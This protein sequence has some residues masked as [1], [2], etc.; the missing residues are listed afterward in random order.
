MKYPL[1]RRSKPSVAS[2]Q[3]TSAAYFNTVF[4]FS[5]LPFFYK[6]FHPPFY[7]PG[8]FLAECFD[9]TKHFA[10]AVGVVLPINLMMLL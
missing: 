7:R 10:G 2:L 6:G 4:L 1:N 3:E 8:T 5:Q 9:I